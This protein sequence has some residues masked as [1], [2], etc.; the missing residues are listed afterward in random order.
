M[1]TKVINI[2]KDLRKW[3]VDYIINTIH[4]L[5]SEDSEEFNKWTKSFKNEEAEFVIDK[6][7]V[8]DWGCD[9][10]E[11]ITEEEAVKYAQLLLQEILSNWHL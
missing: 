3:L 10:R 5:K 11:N 6:E 1:T 8:N 4:E 7:F 2:K 9:K